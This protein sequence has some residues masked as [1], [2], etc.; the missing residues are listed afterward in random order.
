MGCR[1]FYCGGAE[2]KAGTGC[3]SKE[4]KGGNRQD[5]PESAFFSPANFG[6]TLMIVGRA[7]ER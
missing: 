5:N 6:A 2:L 3:P 7:A 4:G 1:A